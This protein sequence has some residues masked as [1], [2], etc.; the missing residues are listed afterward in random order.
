MT[1]ISS[2][3][4]LMDIIRDEMHKEDVK[5]MSRLTGVSTSALYSIRRGKTRWPR[6]YTLFALTVACDLIISVRRKR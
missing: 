2:G 3:S 6:D 5:A 1:N 4:D